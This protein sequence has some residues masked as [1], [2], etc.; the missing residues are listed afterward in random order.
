M[1]ACNCIDASGDTMT[2]GFKRIGFRT[3]PKEGLV[4]LF[5]QIKDVVV[6]S[7]YESLYRHKVRGRSKLFAFTK[8]EGFFF[9][10]EGLDLYLNP[11]DYI[12]SHL[13]NHGYY[14]PHVLQSV[15]QYLPADGI[16][17]DVG[18]N[19]GLHSLAVQLARPQATVW[20][21]EPNPR[22]MARLMR[23]KVRNGLPVQL[24]S[25][26]LSDEIRIARLSIKTEGNSGLTSLEPW[27]TT[28]YEEQCS[29]QTTRADSLVKAGQIPNV[30]KIDVEGHEL[31]VLRGFGDYLRSP[32]LR[33]IVFEDNRDA[34][35]HAMLIAARFEVKRISDKES[36]AIKLE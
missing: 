28:R 20:S 36:S 17:W 12:D 1:P 8:H 14:E 18:A 29:V 16:F 9:R 33:A 35:V 34:E 19:I 25:V 4:T 15:L 27:A 3:D 11:N 31:S 26:A 2:D 30:V 5:L 23:S 7:F 6:N 24:Y 13:I 22:V 10:L 21:F 32:H